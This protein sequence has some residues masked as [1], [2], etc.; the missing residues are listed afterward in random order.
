MA[1]IFVPGQV[2]VSD[3]NPGGPTVISNID[4]PMVKVVKLTSANFSTSNVDTMIAA[5]PADAT[6]ISFRLWV[7]TQLA[8]NS[9]AAATLALGNASGGAQFM[10]ANSAAFGTAGTYSVLTPV[11]AIFQNYNIPQG[12]DIQLWARGNS[13][14]GTPTS[15]EMYLVIEYVR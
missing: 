4:H 8:G 9:I 3:A 7:K 10:A 5:F 2:A 13:T 15:G 6:I 1:V 12:P 11:L 14:T